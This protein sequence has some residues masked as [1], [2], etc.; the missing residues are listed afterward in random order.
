MNDIA[1]GLKTAV[2]AALPSH[3]APAA[4]GDQ[5]D[6][7]AGERPT[8]SAFEK[9]VQGTR[10]RPVGS[11]NKRTEYWANFILSRYQSPLVLL[12]EIYSTP[13]AELAKEMACDPD[14]AVK[15][16]KSAAEALAPYVHQRMPT[17]VQLDGANA[18]MLIVGRVEPGSAA[19]AAVQSMGLTLTVAGA[20]V[21]PK[22]EEYQ[23][24][25][26]V[27]VEAS[28]AKSESEKSDGEA[29]P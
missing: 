2:E 7:F 18:G 11:V 28:G 10:G 15:L 27:A 16:R 6:M 3:A 8:L 4:S 26:A 25:D 12:A 14:Q 29:K 5:P 19:A 9:R 23:E 1:N 21:P 22:D 24:I 13:T 20:V 17:A